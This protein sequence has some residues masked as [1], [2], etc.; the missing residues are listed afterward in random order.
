MDARAWTV[1]LLGTL[2]RI[3]CNN[4]CKAAPREPIFSNVNLVIIIIIV[5]DVEDLHTRPASAV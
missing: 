1:G 4:D 3:G 2:H 5:V